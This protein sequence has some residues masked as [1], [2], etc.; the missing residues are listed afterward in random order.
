MTIAYW[1]IAG[2][3]AI[4]FL[5]AGLMKLARPKEA[6]ASSGMAYVE[7]FNAGQVKLIGAAEVVGAIGLIL[8]MLLGIAPILSPIAAV[9]LAVLMAG[10][11]ATHIRRKE[12]F[13]PPLVLAILSAIVAVLGFLALA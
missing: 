7:D 8:P 1:I 4:A 6:L 2:I 9:A 3:L 11:V 12:Q 10:A 13:I 5:A